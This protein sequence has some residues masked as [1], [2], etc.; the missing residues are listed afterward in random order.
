MPTVG[1]GTVEI[2]I[3]TGDA[4]R[5]FYVA[6]F[7]DGIHVLH[8]FQKTTEKT[9]KKDIDTAVRRYRALVQELKAGKKKGRR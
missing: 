4:Y 8:A 7:D 3:N 9:S 2:I 5:V 6:K 1:P